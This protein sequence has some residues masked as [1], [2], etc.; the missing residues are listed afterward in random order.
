[1]ITRSSFKIP[2]KK[3]RKA[4]SWEIL[5]RYPVSRNRYVAR[6]GACG[7]RSHCVERNT[8][9]IVEIIYLP[10]PSPLWFCDSGH[11][12]RH[13]RRPDQSPGRLTDHQRTERFLARTSSLQSHSPTF[14]F[15][16]RK[17]LDSSYTH[18]PKMPPSAAY[19]YIIG[20]HL[21][22]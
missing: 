12:Y 2:L 15:N 16:C 18:A 4:L 13:R 3:E 5:F 22:T 7:A 6:E 17:S 19:F 11:H 9:I 1:M 20:K 8:K 14:S 10:Y 21:P